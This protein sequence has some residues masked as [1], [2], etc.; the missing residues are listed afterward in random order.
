MKR[1][2]PVLL[3]V[4]TSLFVAKCT[5]EKRLF[6]PGY[7]IEWKKKIPQKEKDETEIPVSA[8]RHE[9]DLANHPVTTDPVAENEIPVNTHLPETQPQQLV[10]EP[11]TSSEKQPTIRTDQPG[12]SETEASTPKEQEKDD[13]E[14]ENKPEFELFGVMSFGLYF[15]SLALAIIGIV[16]LSS[17]YFFVV[18]GFMILLSLIF[19]IISVDKYRRDRSKYRRNS[20]GYFGL[21]ASAATI[22]FVALLVL[23]A[24]GLGSF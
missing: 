6:Q 21:I 7:S 8:N 24:W 1:F 4:F 11:I 23:L 12:T 20:F 2:V 17:P 15:C 9:P 5:I 3:L 14:T 13:W 10:A 16:L 19:G 22:S 18:A